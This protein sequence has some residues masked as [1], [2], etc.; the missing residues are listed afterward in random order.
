[1]TVI[2]CLTRL[3]SDSWSETGGE[4]RAGGLVRLETLLQ[5]CLTVCAVVSA[6]VSPGEL[7]GEGDRTLSVITEQY[8]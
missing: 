2:S 5:W 1:M 7:F 6:L 3:P 4:D 8:H